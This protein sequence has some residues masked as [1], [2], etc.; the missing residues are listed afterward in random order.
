MVIELA[1]NA[2]FNSF[3]VYDRAA[4][5]LRVQIFDGA[6]VAGHQASLAIDLGG[7]VFV[8]HA[9]TTVDFAGNAFGF[10]LDGPGGLFLSDTSLNADGADHMWAYQGEGDSVQIASWAAGL[11]TPNEYVLAFEDLAS[12]APGYDGD[13]QDF[14]VMVESVV[15]VPVPG[16]VLLGFLGL[17]Y[18]GMR[19]RKVA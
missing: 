1:G 3:G 10:Y 2:T 15:P 8:D 11:W 12:G 6:A 7:S 17:G 19:L 4:P 9:D 18:A 14:V 16:A 5:N 13:F